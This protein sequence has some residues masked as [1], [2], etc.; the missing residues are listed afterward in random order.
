MSS[1]PGFPIATTVAA[2]VALSGIVAAQ[3]PPTPAPASKPDTPPVTRHIEAARKAAGAEWRQAVEFTCVTDPNSAA[4][5]PWPDDPLIEP[6]KVFDNAY[7]FGRTST[8]VWAITTSAGIVL[9]DSAHPGQLETVV[10]SGLRKVG[11]DPA[12]VRYVLITHG[13]DDHYGDAFYFQQR[14]ARVVASAA[15]W[16]L[17]GTPTGPGRG[18]GGA[19][20]LTPPRPQAPRPPATP[21][22]RDIVVVDG[23]QITVGDVTFT[24]VLIPGHTPGALGFIFSVRDGRNSYTAALFGGSVLVPSFVRDERQWQQYIDSIAHWADATQKA[25]VDVEVQ[26]HPIYDN[27]D[28]KLARLKTRRA[29]EPHPFVVGRDGYHRFLTVMSECSQAQLVRRGL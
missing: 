4:N 16:E 1:K 15:D 23:Q 25:N 13:H 18:G 5:F 20:R 24:S 29:G 10:L 6:T 2:A 8:V 27:R 21:P 17:M 9:I 22:M 28:E 19:A 26:N 3:A 14:G 11:L 12:N 7:V